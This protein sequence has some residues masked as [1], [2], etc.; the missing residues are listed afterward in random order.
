MTGNLAATASSAGL[1]AND[2]IDNSKPMGDCL[3][4]ITLLNK[5]ITD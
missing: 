3:T 2:I 5:A 1:V 4:Y